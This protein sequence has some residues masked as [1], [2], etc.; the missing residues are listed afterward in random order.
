MR[1]PLQAW[2]ALSSGCMQACPRVHYN[3]CEGQS[4]MIEKATHGRTIHRQVSLAPWLLEDTHMQ[5]SL[6]FSEMRFRRRL[7]SG[8][9]NP[10]WSSARSS[11]NPRMLPLLMSRILRGTAGAAGTC[12][13][14]SGAA[15][16]T[17]TCHAPLRRQAVCRVAGMGEQRPRRSAYIFSGTASTLVRMTSLTYCTTGLCL[18]PDRVRIRADVSPSPQ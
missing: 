5:C 16:Q 12:D 17:C 6:A 14:A 13:G 3:V 7:Y 15:T 2:Q 10:G 1:S 8:S 9:W 11:P 18:V 4:S